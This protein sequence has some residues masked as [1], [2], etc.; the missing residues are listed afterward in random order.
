MI[1]AQAAAIL[2]LAQQALPSAP[3]PKATPGPFHLPANAPPPRATPAPTP[4]AN[5]LKAKADE[6]ELGAVD[7]NVLAGPEGFAARE[8]FRLRLR[9]AIHRHWE[10]LIPEIAKGKRTWYGTVKDGKRGTAYVTFML[11]K[12]GSVTD[13]VLEASSG[14]QQMDQ[15]ALQAVKEIQPLPLW[16]TFK[17]EELQIRAAFMYNPKHVPLSSR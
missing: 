4:E 11:H 3:E 9:P 13:I 8:F 12:D 2:L 16:S 6:P 5:D 10:V 7:Q 1:L 15:A 17:K 14:D